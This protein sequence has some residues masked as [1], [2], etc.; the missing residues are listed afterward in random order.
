MQTN[1]NYADNILL[2]WKLQCAEQKIDLLHHAKKR[3]STTL[4]RIKWFFL[5]WLALCNY[6]I[7]A[8]HGLATLRIDKS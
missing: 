3:F 8:L 7:V 1:I 6:W 5:D 4:R 2:P